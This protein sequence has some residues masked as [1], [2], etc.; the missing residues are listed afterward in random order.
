MQDPSDEHPGSLCLPHG[1]YTTLTQHFLYT[2]PTCISRA[3]GD[4]FEFLAQ[5][6]GTQT[7]SPQHL[8]SPLFNNNTS[9]FSAG[10]G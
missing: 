1:C 6:S 2:L 5:H 7:A 8:A 3:N 9:A 4:L 10:R